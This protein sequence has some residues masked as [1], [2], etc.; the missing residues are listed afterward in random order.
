MGTHPTLHQNATGLTRTI[1]YATCT[2]EM[3]GRKQSLAEA[4]ARRRENLSVE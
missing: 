1:Q 2:Q 4:S 3:I